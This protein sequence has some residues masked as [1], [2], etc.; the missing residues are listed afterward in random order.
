MRNTDS[1]F[2][3]LPVRPHAS[4]EIAVQ[5]ITSVEDFARLAPD[6][7][8]IHDEAEAASIFNSWV[9]QY[10]WWQVYGAGQ[11]LRV[12]VALEHGQA[13]G[14]LA[15]Y[16]QTIRVL[17]V[18]VRLLRFVGSGADTHPDDLGPVIARGREDA[19]AR[20]LAEAALHV[21]DADALI[22]TDI[23]PRSSLPRALEHAA[24]AARREPLASVS[25]RIAYI[26]LPRS[27]PQFLSSLRSDKRTRL[28]SARRKIE[29]GHGLRFFVWHDAAALD[30]AV[31][32]LAELHRRRWR[33][34]GGSDS[35]AT[36]QY[37]EFHRGIMKALLPRGWL[38][39]YCLELD[40]DMAAMTYC[41][42]FRNR[43][44]LMQAGF[45][46]AR[47][48]LNPGKA[49]LGYALEHAIGEGN[50]V[51]DFL[52]GEHRYKD[53]LATGYRDTQAVRIFR[54]TLGALAYRLRRVWLPSWKARLVGAPPPK[55]LP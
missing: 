31:D 46:P 2:H 33:E 28:K 30:S 26:D 36:P 15:L 11:P 35:F 24:V 53:E 37:L 50:D 39:L 3:F 17:G 25:E 9:W 41:Y 32:R 29:S 7:N 23:A 34:A 18:R 43:V 16:I 38:R 6:W 47:A 27:W 54:P 51:F 44:Y 40:G 20:R 19:V 55:L 1:A 14:I 49:L 5:F 4:G 21:S 10:Q 48:K 42:R 13:L 12:L 8:R 45:D 52:R 22:L